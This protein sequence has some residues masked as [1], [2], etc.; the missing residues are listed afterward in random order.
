MNQN[1]VKV[2]KSIP[3]FSSLSE[4]VINQH[5]DKFQQIELK[6]DKILFYQGESSDSVFVLVSGKL[7][8]E[9]TEFSGKSRIIGYI[10][11]GET[12]GELGAL[13]DEPRSFTVRA[14]KDSVLLQLTAKDYIELCHHYPAVMFSSLQP[15][16]TRSRKIIQM[17]SREKSGRHIVIVP[18][19]KNI[20]MKHFFASMTEFSRDYHTISII[21]DYQPEFSDTNM[22]L[23]SV[24]EKIRQIVKSHKSTHKELYILSSYDT[25]LAKVCL[26]KANKVYIAAYDHESKPHVDK[27]LLDKIYSKR[28]PLECPPI[29]ILLHTGTCKFMKIR[30]FGSSKLNSHFIIMYAQ[31]SSR[32]IF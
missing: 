28:Y 15:I 4:E 7:S 29:L 10:E 6:Q 19:N 18:A 12:V 30:P 23:D 2:I 16:V 31:T 14:L 5:I 9:L 8:A 17:I 13:S 11:Q 25:P 32:K 27:Q 26:N 3:I 21:S 22:T 20:S 24:K 1:I